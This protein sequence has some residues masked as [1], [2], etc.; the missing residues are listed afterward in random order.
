MGEYNYNYTSDR[1]YTNH[2]HELAETKVYARYGIEIIRPVTKEEKQRAEERDIYEAID[3]IGY[4]EKTGLH[5]AIQERTREAKYA[6]YNDITIRFERPQ[7]S[8]EDRQRSEFYKLDAYFEQNPNVPFLMMYAVRGEGK[9]VVVDDA[10]ATFTKY[11][12]VDL[13]K[14]YEH[15]KNEEIVVADWVGTSTSYVRDGVMYAPVISNN[16][17]SSTFVPFDIGQLIEYF[18]DVVLEQ[19]GFRAPQLPLEPG[20][21]ECHLYAKMQGSA[22]AK[23]RIYIEDLAR[24]HNY[25]TDIASVRNLSMREASEVITLFNTNPSYVIE[26]FPDTVFEPQPQRRVLGKE[27]DR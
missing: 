27:P 23:Q 18:P 6:E 1:G 22:S 17:P 9:D 4:I 3:Y 2:N 21:R 16:D 5:F 20:Y 15:I 7:N 13:R 14:L 10:H 26:K 25:V 12:F 8:H 19:Q 11:A 24:M